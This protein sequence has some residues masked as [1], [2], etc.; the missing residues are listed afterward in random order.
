MSLR[1]YTTRAMQQRPGRTILTLISIVIGVAAAVSIDIGT[2]TTR[3]TYEQMFAAV[4]GKATLEISAAGGVGFDEDLLAQVSAVSGVLVAAP[5]VEKPSKL[6]V[7]ERQIRLQVMGIDPARDRGVRDYE[8]VAGRQ[9]DKGDELVLDEEFAKLLEI[10]VGDEVGVFTQ[11]LRKPFQVVGLVRPRGGEG[12]RRASLAFMPIGRAQVYFYPRGKSNLI[13]KIQIVTAAGDAEIERVQKQIAALLPAEPKLAVERPA[14]QTQLMEHTLKSSEQGLKLTSLFSL[15]LAWFIILNTFLMNVGERRRHLAIMRAIGATRGQ[16]TRSL[17]VESLLLGVV[18]T[19]LGIAVGVLAAW[20]VNRVL[21]GALDVKLSPVF[22]SLTIRPFL[23]GAAFGL[24]T[25]L[26]GALIPSLLAGKVSPLEGMSRTT[27]RDMGKWSW[28]FLAGGVLAEVVGIL[29]IYGGLTRRLP[30][31]APMYGA[32]L[33]L[34]GFVALG[35]VLLGPLATLVSLLFRPF[36]PVET[37]L[38][39]KQ[40]LRHNLRSAL[41]VGVL[42]IAG[43]TGVG[44]AN[45]ILDNV[46]DVRE[47]SQTAIAGDYFV[48][49]MMPDM[50]SGTAPDLP[51]GLEAELRQVEHIASIEGVAYIQAHLQTR[52]AEGTPAELMGICIAREYP[53]AVPPPFDLIEGDLYQLRQQLQEGQVVL[54]S[55]LAQRIAA[56]AGDSVQLQTVS[57]V[58]PIQVAGIANEYLVGGMSIHMH[59]DWA[60]KRLGVEGYDGFILEADPQFVTTIKPQLE[61]I[62]KRYDVL[63]HSRAQITGTVNQ[64]V[65]GI[66]WSLW[67]LVI[68]GFIVAAFG[69]VNTLTMNVLE[70]TRELGLL[71]IVAMTK[72]QV[73]RTIVTQALIIGGVGLP[74][75]IAM[76]VLTAYMMNLAM[77][78]S[79]GH[80]IEFHTYP[81]LLA[82]TLGGAFLIVL[83]SAI[84]PAI[85]ATRIDVVEAL[86]YE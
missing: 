22:D 65:G 77:M 52:D 12:L 8:I 42:F 55:V 80:P 19:I 9:L 30:I 78:D 6:Y 51:D 11:R 2:A 28:P 5:I 1:K 49:A 64:I 13:D 46:R 83:I 44:M 60:M 75:G 41:T 61:A 54:G 68:L 71:R 57:G 58:Q 66:E 4:T 32:L 16:I 24:G 84:I 81:W 10:E 62:A 67:V 50:A 74:P 85:R 63:L 43:A 47:W 35:T 73:R 70:Q 34:A 36:R 53:D 25:S 26:M 69:V 37:R 56:R 31:D 86:H 23:L 18:G 14:G 45:S 33:V 82:L 3:T 48:R 76:G 20:L 15:L 27:S 17:V 72:A 29:L 39:L 79:F 7:G 59:R 40:V 38:A 21:A